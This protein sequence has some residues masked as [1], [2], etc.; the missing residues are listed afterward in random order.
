MM[1]MHEAAIVRRVIEIAERAG[2]E[3]AAVGQAAGGRRVR[4]GK[5]AAGAAKLPVPENPPLKDPK[6]WKIA[7]KPLARLD[8]AP[9]VNGRLVSGADLQHPALLTA[10]TPACPGTGG[11]VGCVEA[12]DVPAVSAG[13]PVLHPSGRMRGGAARGVSPAGLTLGSGRAS[14]RSTV[15][16]VT[17]ISG[18]TWICVTPSRWYSMGS[19]TVMTLSSGRRRA[20]S[21]E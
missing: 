9:K 6:D 5:L 1:G 8:T 2:W 3:G 19:S 20:V 13:G 10:A 7:G 12:G 11:N 21:A 15:A 18:C 14:A 16:K 17:P 4:S